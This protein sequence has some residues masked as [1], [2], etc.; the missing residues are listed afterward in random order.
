MTIMAHRDRR[1]FLEAITLCP[2]RNVSE[3]KDLV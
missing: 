2:E 3:V 1:Y